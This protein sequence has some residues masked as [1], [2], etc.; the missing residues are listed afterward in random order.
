MFFTREAKLLIPWM[1]LQTKRNAEKV[2]LSGS[3]SVANFEKFNDY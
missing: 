3:G 2:F 1:L